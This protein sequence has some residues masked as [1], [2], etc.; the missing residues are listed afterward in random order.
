M[1]TFYTLI[2]QIVIGSIYTHSIVW[3][4]HKK[5][6][7]KNNKKNQSLIGNII[8]AHFQDMSHGQ[9]NGI[10]QG[11]VLMDFVVEMVLGYADLKLLEKIKTS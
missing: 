6:I 4:L 1:N 5:D 7:A 11:G 10:P 8:D 9:T 3:A 2:F